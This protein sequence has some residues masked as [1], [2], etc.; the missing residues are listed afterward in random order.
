[1]STSY[2][3]P[4][5][6]VTHL[7]LEEGPGHDVLT[8]WVEHGKVGT[9]LLPHGW[10]R[11]LACLLADDQG[12]QDDAMRTHWGGAAVGAVLTDKARLSD[13]AIAISEYGDV[14]TA[15][16]VRARAGARRQDG[17]PTELFGYE[18]EAMTQ[19]SEKAALSVE[20]LRKAALGSAGISQY[21][22]INALADRIGTLER[23]NAELLT[24]LHEAQDAV[25]GKGK[26]P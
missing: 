18:G 13:D 2:N 7:R 23:E 19:Q 4:I 22:A 12:D 6:G 21:A 14:L 8:I 15:G 10:G 9:L 1:M 25:D 20:K 24:A 17:M 26:R 11:R 5:E 3:K 16:T